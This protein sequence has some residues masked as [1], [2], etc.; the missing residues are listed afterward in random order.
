MSLVFTLLI[1][2]LLTWPGSLL[3]RADSPPFHLV[4]SGQGSANLLPLR[5]YGGLNGATLG[6]NSPVGTFYFDSEGNLRLI[7]DPPS[8]PAPKGNIQA[9]PQPQGG[10]TPYGA[11]SFAV[12]PP[13]ECLR[14]GIA[15]LR[16]NVL[17]PQLGSKLIFNG[18]ANFYACSSTLDVWYEV[19]PGYGPPGVTCTPISLFTVPVA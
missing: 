13:S 5:P 11:L 12:G 19:K 6:G 2:S 10:C 8:D 3:V 17:A 4:A 14:G 9:L 18:A 7:T 15:N 1:F 16:Q